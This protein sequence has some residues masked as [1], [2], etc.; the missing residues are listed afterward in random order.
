M[1]QRLSLISDILFSLRPRCPVC[2]KGRLF[3]PWSIAVVE[4]CSSCGHPL[5][6]HDVGDGAAVF[7]IFLLG[8][9]V[10]PLAWALELAAHPPLWVHV[11]FGGVLSL[12]G[13]AVVMPA[14]KAYIMLL[15]QRHRR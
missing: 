9:T 14:V 1:G 11:V 8:F 10:V 6:K 3:K 12:A 5:G 15:E 13:M 2:A 4:T 7:M